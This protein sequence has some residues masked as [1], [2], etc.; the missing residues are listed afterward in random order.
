LNALAVHPVT[1]I[2]CNQFLTMTVVAYN[3]APNFI[4]LNVSFIMRDA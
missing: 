4:K 1:R 3:Q 2:K